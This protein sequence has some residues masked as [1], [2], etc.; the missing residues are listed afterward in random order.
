[1]RDIALFAIVLGALPFVLKRAYFG[2]LLWSWLGYM[3]PHRLSFGAA[4]NFPF[5][6]L[7]GI[8]TLI[9]LPFDKGR[10]GV[11]ITSL[12]VC[13]FLFV[14]WLNLTTIFALNPDSAFHEW[15]RAM[16]VML[17]SFVTIMLVQDKKRLNL[18][19]ITIAVSMGFYG[20]KGGFF[21]IVTGG[22]F[23]VFG[24]PESFFEDN[25]ALALALIMTLPLIRYLQMQVTNKLANWTIVAAMLLIALSVLTSHSRGALLAGTAMALFLWIKSRQKLRLGLIMLAALP[26]MIIQM[27]DTWFSRMETISAYEEDGSAMG[28]I[29]AWW[30]AYNLAKDRPIFGG[31]FNTFTP[32][33][34]GKYAPEPDDFHDAHSIYF[35]I[36]GEHGFVGLALFLALGILSLG[37]AK[38]VVR[39]TRDMRE[40][41]WAHDLGGMIQVC[42]IGYAVGGAFLGLA[43]FDLY[44]HLIAMTVV[45][46]AIVKQHE[47]KQIPIVATDAVDESTGNN[48]LER[49]SGP[50]NP[51]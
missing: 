46:T 45:L 35:E 17:F 41:T 51:R 29:N 10:K 44:Y 15:D 31:G 20:V 28:R 23:L 18:L 25:N 4:Y 30:F 9:A 26:F 6:Q 48:K 22:N 1:M 27:P 12:T 11:P 36:L 42:L 14:L 40:L 19:I 49:I 8:T 16:K 39:K 50:D 38:R 7:V 5:A 3:N 32:E 21:S 2:V 37:A 47:N 13:W 43:Y 34:F 24:P 33:L